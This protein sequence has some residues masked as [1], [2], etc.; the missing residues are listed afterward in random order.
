MISADDNPDR[1]MLLFCANRKQL[2]HINPEHAPEHLK[3]GI[4][5]TASNSVASCLGR[6]NI[7]SSQVGTKVAAENTLQSW[8]MLQ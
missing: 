1:P 3:Y 8:E 2:V 5:T 4:H 7:L 6:S